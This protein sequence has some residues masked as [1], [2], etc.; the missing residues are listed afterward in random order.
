MTFILQRL[1]ELRA[2]IEAGLSV[3]TLPATV[4]A[5]TKPVTAAASALGAGEAVNV[6]V[7]NPSA[8]AE[9]AYLGDANAQPIELPP[10]GAISLPVGSLADVHVRSDADQ[11]ISYFAQRS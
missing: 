1:K 6:F 3:R 5:G 2:T 7:Q 8:N 10:G 11:T 9:T 4:E